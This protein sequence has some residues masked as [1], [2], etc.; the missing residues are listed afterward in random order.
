MNQFLLCF[1]Y[2]KIYLLLLLNTETI[3]V[4]VPGTSLDT[5]VACTGMQM[6][7]VVWELAS[8]VIPVEMVRDLVG[9]AIG[10]EGIEGDDLI[11]LLA[12][13]RVV[14]IVLIVLHRSE[15]LRLLRDALGSVARRLVW[16]KQACQEVVF[17]GRAG[18]G[19]G[20]GALHLVACG[21]GR[22]LL[23][24]LNIIISDS[25]LFHFF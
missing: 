8:V 10:D 15:Q 19:G 4:T 5:P 7:K 6:L 23:Y 12:V 17:V 18:A 25:F 20:A 9:S 11:A 22:L 3:L 2:K 1:F 21:W 14:L 16:A 13:L 24:I